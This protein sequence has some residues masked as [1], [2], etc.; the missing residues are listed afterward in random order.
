MKQ[1]KQTNFGLQNLQKTPERNRKKKLA[2]KTW[3]EKLNAQD[4]HTAK[5]V[6][7]LENFEPR[8]D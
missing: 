1:W 2:K 7:R 4:L 8:N 5:C 6:K 3:H